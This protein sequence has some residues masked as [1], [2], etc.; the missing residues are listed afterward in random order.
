MYIYIWNFYYICIHMIYWARYHIS[1]ILPLLLIPSCALA[2]D[3]FLAWAGPGPGPMPRPMCRGRGA[4]GDRRGAR[5]GPRGSSTCTLHANNTCTQRLNQ[6][7]TCETIG[8]H[9]YTHVYI[10]M[11]RE[12]EIHIC[13]CLSGLSLSLSPSVRLSLS[14]RIYPYTYT[15]IYI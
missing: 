8:I 3:P 5:G 14:L 1:I 12:R 6:W 15:Y 7:N 2:L 13:I 4:W 10:Y 11:E 9:A